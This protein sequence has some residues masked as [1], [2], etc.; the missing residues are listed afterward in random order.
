M[1]VSRIEDAGMKSIAMGIRLIITILVMF[2]FVSMAIGEEEK[3]FDDS[4]PE[5]KPEKKWRIGYYE[6]G[7][8]GEYQN[9]LVATM[10]GL[11]ALGWMAPFNRPPMEDTTGEKLWNYFAEHCTS[12]YIEIVKDGFYTGE[13]NSDRRKTVFDK[14]LKRIT[15]TRDIDLLIAM[16]T[17]AGIDLSSHKHTTPTIVMAV[18][19]A[20]ASGIITSIDD[21]G[22]DY[23]HARV[24]PERY[25]RQIRIFHYVIGFKSLG[26]AYKDTV[27]GRSYAA[28][29]KVKKVA[30]ER[31]FK[32]IQCHIKDTDD[33][34]EEEKSIFACY[35]KLASSAEAI[36]VTSQKGINKETIPRLVDI[37]INNKV[38]T[39]SQAGSEEV[40]YGFMLSIAQ[41]GFQ[42]V[43]EFYAKT[44]GAI[45]NGAMP[46]ELKQIFEEPS[47]IAINLKTADKIGILPSIDILSVA[48]ELYQNITTPGVED[49][50][51]KAQETSVKQ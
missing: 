31:G 36:Y 26:I 49:N 13:W 27:S 30:K 35:S 4:P 45:L 51:N 16:G 18:S 8:Y 3:T 12:D 43:G 42:P 15:T 24:D 23:I 10:E 14:L 47:K 7:D 34:K 22:N 11:A 38:P 28:V 17:W 21:S 9:T 41:A 48:D 33:L 5:K 39:F 1:I 29:R 32:I 20:V 25:E 50:D 46:R 40:K 19:D 2:T 37:A 6:G 44:M